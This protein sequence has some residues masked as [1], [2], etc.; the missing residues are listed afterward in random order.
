[1]TKST[2]L[3]IILQVVGVTSLCALIA[4]VMPMPWMATIHEWLGLG[5]MPTGNI[6]EYLARSLS[7][8]YALFG[9]L[10]L[11]L[12]T[13]VERYRRVVWCMGI[14]V[15]VLGVIMIGIDFAAGMPVSW[16]ASE[17]PT[18]A[19]AGLLLAWLS[20]SGN[21]HALPSDPSR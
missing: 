11:V 14:S 16:I 20:R 2:L 8:F 4:V 3:R 1:M 15:G 6:V 21:L 18:A 12:A 7:A 19:A 13:D 9:F 10:C 17:G 5:A